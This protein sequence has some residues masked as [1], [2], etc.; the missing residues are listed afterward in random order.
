MSNEITPSE[1]EELL[2]NGSKVNIIDVRT[3]AEFSEAHLKG[4]LNMPLHQLDPELLRREFADD[5]LYLICQKGGRGLQACSRLSAAGFQNVTNVA[6]GTE[7]CT[8]AGLSIER[9]R[10]AMSLERQVRIAAGS[11]VLLGVI[12][13]WLVHPAFFGV[14]AFVGAGLVF[15]GVTNTCGM[16][17]LL[18]RMPWNQ[19]R[20]KSCIS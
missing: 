2:R 1:L 14:S 7:A 17:M 18:A 10:P 8:A 20:K 12:L 15:A 13:G 16:G 9:G 3:P 11:L 5:P 19:C 4:A 6:G